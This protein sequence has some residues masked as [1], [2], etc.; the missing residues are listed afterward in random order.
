MTMGGEPYL[1]DTNVLIYATDPDSPFHAAARHALTRLEQAGATLFISNQ[2]LREY[3]AVLSRP[4]AVGVPAQAQVVQ[5][6]AALARQYEVAE[7]TVAVRQALL[8]LVQTIPVGGRQ[9]HDANLVAT[10]LAYG[11]THLLTNN[12]THFARFAHVITVGPL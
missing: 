1:V 11:I 9:I 6:L 4:T 8:T 10:M 12:P 7:D 3:Y 2:I 5:N